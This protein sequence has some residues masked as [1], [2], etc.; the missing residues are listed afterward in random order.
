M[1]NRHLESIAITWA[2]RAQAE[3]GAERRFRQLAEQL[4]DLGAQSTVIVLTRN[5]QEDEGRHAVMCAQVARE[6]G[7]STGF[8]RFST[9]TH[10][11][12]SWSQRQSPEERLLC[13]V[14]L[15]CC[16]TET[17]NASLLN[18][19]YGASPRTATRK[20]IHQILKDEVKHSQIGWAHLTSEAQKRD[21]YFLAD[22]LDEMLDISVKD[23]L[24]LPVP[25][26]LED[27]DSFGY[28]VMPMALRLNQ[29]KET[30]DQ[31]VLPGFE[32]FGINTFKAR[33]WI[34][35]K[36]QPSTE[37]SKMS[38]LNLLPSHRA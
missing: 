28:G 11:Q 31:V 37:V 18:S 3:L 9:S 14:T 27:T 8:E 17:F 32:R 30:M 24:F 23:D 33:K 10:I 2:Q 26:D 7:H 16:I 20:V 29:F 4:A 25:E 15:M 38:K 21:C 22:Y 35:E 5:A 13:E 19:I 34:N 36:S 6:Y 12:K 1:T